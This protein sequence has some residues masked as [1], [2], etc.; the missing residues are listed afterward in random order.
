MCRTTLRNIGL[1]PAFASAFAFAFA[2]AS[3]RRCVVLHAW[4]GVKHSHI[5]KK[6]EDTKERGGAVERTRISRVSCM[7]RLESESELE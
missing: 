3:A 4:H 6:A 1:G 7:S 2:F 5:K